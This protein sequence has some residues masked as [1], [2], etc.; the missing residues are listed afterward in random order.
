MERPRP[1]RHRA[2][3]EV[4]AGAKSPRTAE[5]TGNTR[6]GMMGPVGDGL[7]QESLLDARAESARL[8]AALHRKAWMIPKGPFIAAGRLVLA[9]AGM[10]GVVA[11]GLLLA[12]AVALVQMHIR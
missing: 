9:L 11:L 1:P 12:A 4:A 8:Q 3:G 10:L 7:V 5:T 2:H 6:G